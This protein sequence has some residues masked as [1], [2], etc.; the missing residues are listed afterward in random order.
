M[1]IQATCHC[2]ATQLTLSEPPLRVTQCNCTFCSKR[3]ALWAYYQPDQVTLTNITSSATYQRE[4][5]PVAHHHCAICGCST[6][7]ESPEWVE[8]KPHPTRKKILINARLLDDLDLS[9][10]PIDFVDGRHLW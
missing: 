2:K 9:P 6:Y 10:L 7:G 8:G 3:G 4:G 5:H 1:P